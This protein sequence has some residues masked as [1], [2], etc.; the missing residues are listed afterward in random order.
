MTREER[1]H[2]LLRIARSKDGMLQLQSLRQRLCGPI[3]VRNDDS[4]ER[5]IKEILDAEFP[6][7]TSPPTTITVTLKRG[8]ESW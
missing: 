5:L 6:P 8:C 7:S 1:H 2:H 3:P 4:V